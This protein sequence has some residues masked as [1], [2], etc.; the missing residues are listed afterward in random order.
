MAKKSLIDTREFV[1]EYFGNNR[2][3]QVFLRAM[4]IAF[5]VI[6][7]DTD[8]YVTNLLDPLHCKA[9]LLPLLS[10]YVGYNYNP[11]ERVLTNRWITKLYP[12]LVRNRGNEIGLSLAIAMAICLTGDPD[13]FEINEQSFS[14]EFDKR[15]N[16]YGQLVD[17]LKIYMHVNNYLPI[18]QELLE[19]VR[20]AGMMLEFVPAQNVTS[21]ETVVLTDEYAIVKY[22]YIS[23]KLLS[24]NDIDIYVQNNWE[25][26]I[27][28][29][30]IKH[31]KWKHLE[32]YVW[33]LNEKTANIDP[34]L[35]LENK[36]WGELEDTGIEAYG[37]IPGLAPYE[38]NNKGN[39]SAPIWNT[40]GVHLIDGRFCDRYGNDLNR[41]VDIETGKILYGDGTWNGEYIKE[42]R[43]FKQNLTTGEEQYTG[44]YFDVSN[45]AKVMNT[46]YKLLDDGIFSGFFLSNDD[47][48]IYNSENMNSSFKLVEETTKINGNSTIVWRVYDSKTN[49]KYNWYVNMLDR[50]FYRDEEGYDITKTTNR[51]PFSETTYIGK[52]AFLMR[53]SETNG[54]VSMS[55][56]KYF[57]NSYGDIVDPSGNII[58]SK[59]DRY[60]VSDSTM[61]G[62]SEV[63]N[64]Q[65]QLSTFDGTN[66]LQREWSFIKDE[67][68]RDKHGRNQTNDFEEYERVTDPRYKFEFSIFDI[69][70][71][72]RE[73]TGTDLIRFLSNDE[74]CKL[75]VDNGYISIP[76]FITEFDSENAS[77][78]LKIKTDMPINYSL[79]DV[80]KTM[81]IRFENKNPNDEINPKWDIYVDWVANIKNNSLFNTNDLENP[82]LFIKKGT[83]E[84]RTLHWTGNPI[85]ITP[86]T[87]DGTTKV[88]SKGGN[89]K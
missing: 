46:Y 3:F 25:V 67:D 79:G 6:K 32:D 60:K 43:I 65:A 10:N 85:Y 37:A 40:T 48:I 30:A 87:Y 82:I 71:P 62:F 15:E 89:T 70:N 49:M 68:M 11:R 14:M 53:T 66:I 58:L 42:T 19:T 74:L 22:D 28:E 51:I 47:Y 52:K 13:D 24:I 88:Y 72:V 45:P 20:P 61:I 54:V 33:G 27:D 80:F 35:I 8:H 39:V 5:S 2:E 56:T 59:K 29:H 23:G 50:R 63:H 34:K 44:M 76:L 4:N 12:L 7:S 38:M 41:Y 1:P 26:L 64:D 16:K 81:N 9:K 31:Y 36:T 69:G 73:Y 55:A 57:V 86:K 83:I 78:V 75:K 21:S 77:G 18:L 84:K 17:C